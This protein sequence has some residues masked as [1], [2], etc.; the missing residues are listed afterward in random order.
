MTLNPGVTDDQLGQYYRRMTAIANRLGK[1]LEFDLVMEALQGIHDGQVI[2]KPAVV[3]KSTPKP[4]LS[5]L[6]PISTITVSATSVKFVAKDKFKLRK[7][8]GICSYLGDN[9]CKWFLSGNG[10]T[11]DPISEQTLRY[12]KLRKS[13]VDVQIIKELGGEEKSEATLTEVFF[14]MEKQAN[15]EKGVLLTNGYANIFYVKDSSGVLRAVRVLWDDDGWHVTAFEVSRPDSWDAGR[16]VFSR[17]LVLVLLGAEVS[18][19]A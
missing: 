5:L 7:D 3:A 16:Q 12:A 19:Q 10:K 8:G 6:E 18:A 4:K 9:F 2:A 17:N 1:S 11:E 13:S 14:L 15:G